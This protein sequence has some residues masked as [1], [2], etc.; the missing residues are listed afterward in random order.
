M[1]Y[2][3]ITDAL[4]SICLRLFRNDLASNCTWKYICRYSSLS[5]YMYMWKNEKQI[6]QD[7]Q[8]PWPMTMQNVTMR[9]L[10]KLILCSCPWPLCPVPSSTFSLPPEQ[11]IRRHLRA[12]SI[13]HFLELVFFQTSCPYDDLS[14]YKVQQLKKLKLSSNKNKIPPAATAPT[15]VGPH[16]AWSYVTSK[17]MQHTCK[18]V[19]E[20]D[21]AVLQNN[22]LTKPNMPNMPHE[23]DLERSKMVNPWFSKNISTKNHQSYNCRHLK[24][25]PVL[26]SPGHL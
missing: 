25:Q 7:V 8:L 15:S 16:G 17:K 1:T 21:H 12:H 20:P 19:L 22:S 13:L 4:S 24:P 18:S 10:E 9:A 14:L 3:H 11:G 2:Q 5:L 6:K 23:I 26:T